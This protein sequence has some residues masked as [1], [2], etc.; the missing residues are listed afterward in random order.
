MRKI[1]QRSVL[2]GMGFLLASFTPNLGFSAE[3][4]AMLDPSAQAASLCGGEKGGASLTRM[5]VMASSVVAPA[6]SAVASMPLYPDLSAP[7]FPVSTSSDEAKRY[8]NQGLML[9]YGFNHAGAVRSF[10]EAQRI[11]PNCALCW[12]G[13]AV[14]LGPNINAPMDDRDRA[15]TLAAI[16]RALALRDRASPVEQAL[17]DAV[18]RRYSRDPKADRAKL[19]AAYADAMLDAAHRFPAQDDVAVLAAEAAMDTSPW[20]YWQRDKRTPIN[21][22]VGEAVRLVEAVLA[23]N[24]NHAQAAH[25]YIHLLEASDPKRAEAAAD[26]L[27]KPLTPSAGHLV[28]MPGHIYQLLGRHKDSIRV[29]IAAARADE[30]WIKWSNDRGM[31]RYGY[32]PHNIHFIVTSA[33]MAGDMATA[34]REASRLH[35]LLDVETSSKI[36]WIQ[37]ID[38]APFLAMA[39]FARPDQILAMPAPDPR[40]PYATAMRHYARAVAQAQRR[41]RAGFD[42]EIAAVAALRGSGQFAG[43]IEQGVP[44]NDLLSIAEAV[45]RGRFAFAQGRYGEAARHYRAATALEGRL[46]YQEPPYWYY[47]VSQSLGAALYRAGRYADASLQFRVALLR[48]PGNGWALYGLAQSE[49]AQGH[50]M[51][52]AAARK[53][54]DRAWLGDRALLRMERL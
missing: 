51:E 7:S 44:A 16:D 1:V 3:G 46:P 33:Q 17:I 42:R 13:E 37:A 32:Y 40:L 19:D 36:G 20:N 43:M 27:G 29:N 47:P 50:A 25:L 10:R 9:N 23:R 12:W 30:A 14:A 54:L 52:A 4:L 15:T 5:L 31:V 48:A 49:Q 22:Q 41:N 6:S 8:F 21:S 28:H 35:S 45:A 26:R 34:I 11:D 18:A 24:P 2:A 38:A 53:A 39:Q